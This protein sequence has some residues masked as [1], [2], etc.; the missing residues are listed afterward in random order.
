MTQSPIFVCPP[1]VL[2]FSKDI[3]LRVERPHYGIPKNRPHL[4]RTYH[5]HHKQKL[6]LLRSVHDQC[7]LYTKNGMNAKF[8]ETY[9]ARD[10][11]C[12]KTDDTT[13]TGIQTLVALEPK[14]STNLDCKPAKILKNGS[15]IA[16]NGV[17]IK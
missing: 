16:F 13:D 12:L 11:T 14:M 10:F 9:P 1:D 7:F 17:D 5:N 8:S 6:S 2:Q 15:S 3:L 4:F